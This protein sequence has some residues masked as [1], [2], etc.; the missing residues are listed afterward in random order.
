MHGRAFSGSRPS[1]MS[2]MTDWSLPP[3]TA[4]TGAGDRHRAGGHLEDA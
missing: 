1:C 4:H 2:T 3:I